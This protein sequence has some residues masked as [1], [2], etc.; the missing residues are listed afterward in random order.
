MRLSAHTLKGSASYF[1]AEPL[2]QAALA[3][4]VLGRT[5]SFDNS[6]ELL[7]TLE[8]EVTRVL[9]ALEIGPPILTS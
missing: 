2:V 6:T 4:E 5:E 7:A 8:H 3:L 1:G 9:A